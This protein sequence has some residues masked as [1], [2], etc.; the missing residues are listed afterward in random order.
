[1]GCIQFGLGTCGLVGA[2]ETRWDLKALSTLGPAVETGFGAVSEF[3]SVC[4]KTLGLVRESSA[5]SSRSR[6]GSILKLGFGWTESRA[7]VACLWAG[8]DGGADTEGSDGA[9]ENVV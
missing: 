2:K 9:T 7:T 8:P 1:M 3:V 4:R 5:Q 6:A